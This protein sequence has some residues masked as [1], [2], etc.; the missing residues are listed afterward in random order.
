M[1]VF[2]LREDVREWFA[3]RGEYTL[4]HDAHNGLCIRIDDDN[5]ALEFM[6]TWG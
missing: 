3:E 4:H 5:L 6:L 1:A 2:D